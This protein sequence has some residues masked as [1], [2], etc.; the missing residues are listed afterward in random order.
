ML[1]SR[2]MKC[3]LILLTG[4]SSMET[5]ISYS[6][7]SQLESMKSLLIGEAGKSLMEILYTMKCLLIFS[8]GVAS[9]C[10]LEMPISYNME[11]PFFINRSSW[12][13]SHGNAHTIQYEMSI[14]PIN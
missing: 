4:M 12:Y 8:T 5:P 14:D 11:F 7:K 9:I 1:T 13:L 3:P 10:L 6:M 2:T